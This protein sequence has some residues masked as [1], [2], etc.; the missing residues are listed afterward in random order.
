MAPSVSV[1]RDCKSI[2]RSVKVDAMDP[3]HGL[4]FHRG[5]PLSGGYFCQHK[6]EQLPTN[7]AYL[8]TRHSEGRDAEEQKAEQT[9]IW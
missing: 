2:R 1:V 6:Q 3:D 7:L 4:C 5:H 8:A 9:E